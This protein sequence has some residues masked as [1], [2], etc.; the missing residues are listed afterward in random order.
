MNRPAFAVPLLALSL[1][2]AGCSAGETP[3]I[4]RALRPVALTSS[5]DLAAYG[6]ADAVSD[7]LRI[8]CTKGLEIRQ[9]GLQLAADS[10]LVD[11]QAQAEIERLRAAAEGA[12]GAELAVVLAALLRAHEERLAALVAG[13][14][15][16]AKRYLEADRKVSELDF[17]LRRWRLQR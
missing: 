2:L 6:V 12:E 10:P 3:K 9:E 4:N 5:S 14:K 11:G 16:K 17:G 8:W 15:F 1:S 7:Q 13:P